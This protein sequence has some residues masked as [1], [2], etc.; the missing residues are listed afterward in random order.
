MEKLNAIIL[1]PEEK[2]AEKIQVKM[3]DSFNHNDVQYNI[4]TKGV[5][6]SK[7]LILG[8]KRILNLPVPF[9]VRKVDYFS[10]YR[11]GHQDPIEWRKPSDGAFTAEDLY[12][13]ENEETTPNGISKALLG[14]RR[15][16]KMGSLK[17]MLI[18]MLVLG[19]V[20]AL[21]VFLPQILGMIG[22]G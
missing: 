10:Y 5:F 2:K 16:K 3:G 9:P 15:R 17:W 7:R 12:I 13:M 8:T 4:K 19:G 22:M 21:L 14:A 1:Y 6:A 11:A 18:L 20:G